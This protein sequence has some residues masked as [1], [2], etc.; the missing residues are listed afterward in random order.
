VAHIESSKDSRRAAS[1]VAGER[2]Q[3]VLGANAAMA[4]APRFVRARGEEASAGRPLFACGAR[5]C[6]RSN[7]I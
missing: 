2:E 3:N 1:G 6:R 7:L 4:A 5:R